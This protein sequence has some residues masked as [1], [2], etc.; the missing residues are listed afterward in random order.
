MLR[1][2]ER[3]LRESEGLLCDQHATRYQARRLRVFALSAAAEASEEEGTRE[4]AQMVGALEA[5]VDC[6]QAHLPPAHPELAF[7]RHRLAEALAQQA[8]AA[9]PGSVARRQLARR[10]RAA[11]EASVH[12][13]ATAYGSDHPQVARWRHDHERQYRQYM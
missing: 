1:A 2:A 7:F 12:A 8:A 11:A 10:G 3:V 6:M 13:I 5:C 4:P 9:A